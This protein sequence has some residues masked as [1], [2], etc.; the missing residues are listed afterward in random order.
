MSSTYQLLRPKFSTQFCH[1]PAAGV[2]TRLA[3]YRHAIVDN[4][5]E[6]ILG[7]HEPGRYQQVKAAQPFAYERIEDLWQEDDQDNFMEIDDDTSSNGRNGETDDDDN[8][9]DDNPDDDNEDG[10]D[11]QRGNQQGNATTNDAE[12]TQANEAEPIETTH[13]ETEDNNSEQTEGN[14]RRNANNEETPT[15]DGS[16]R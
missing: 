1:K 4:P 10:Y 6:N 8:N 5:L 14:H 3:T 9:G 13:S 2:D 7:L 11:H 15:D 12:P 16:T